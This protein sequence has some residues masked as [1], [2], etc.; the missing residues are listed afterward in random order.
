MLV[1]EKRGKLSVVGGELTALDDAPPIEQ[2]SGHSLSDIFENAP[3]S[4]TE[5]SD[6]TKN[7]AQ[8][9][10][11]KS[12]NGQTSIPVEWTATQLKNHPQADCI[13]VLRSVAHE[14][15]LKNLIERFDFIFSMMNDYG[16][17]LKVLPDNHYKFIWV[18]NAFKSITGYDIDVDNTTTILADLYHPDD[19]S[20]MMKHFATVREGQGG[21]QEYRIQTKSGHVR[22]MREYA[23]LRVEDGYSV[24]CGSVSDITSNV[25]AEQALN[26]YAMQQGVIAEVGM[27]AVN[28]QLDVDDFAGQVL[29]LIL[30]LMEAPYCT[31]IE[32]DEENETFKFHTVAGGAWQ[33]KIASTLDDKTSYLGYVLHQNDAV[34]VND[35]S[36]ENRF[37]K[38]Q[39]L[40]VNNI[41]SSVSVVVPMQTAPFGILNLHSLK[42]YAFTPENI[43]TLQMIAN[44]I[45]TYIQQKH[46]QKA[47]H[48]HHMIAQALSDIA[49][50]LNSATELDDILLIILNF[51]AQIVPVVDSSNIML[52]DRERKTATISIRHNVSSEVV[53]TPSGQEMALTDI[54]LYVQMMET[55]KPILLNDVTLESRWH[56]VPA[57]HWIQSWIGAPIF[58]GNEF[59][60][61]VNLDSARRN[62]FTQDHLE[63][64]EVFMNHAS[65]AI[66][67]ARQAEKLKLEVENQTRQL[68]SERAQLQAFFHATGEGIFYSIS[69]T[70]LF[71]NQKLC[72]MMGYSNEELLGRQSTMLRPLQL[73]PEEL[74]QR[75]RIENELRTTGVSHSE[76]RFQRKNGEIFI[77]AVTAS[78]VRV[79]DDRVVAVTIIRDI[80]EEIKVQEQRN[81]FISHAAHE[82]RNPITALNTR[83]YLMNKKEQVTTT[84]V[85]KVEQ[86]VKKMNALVSGLLDFSRYQSGRIP[87]TFESVI[88]QK[89]LGDV[90]DIQQPEADKENQT[91]VFEMPDEPITMVADELRLYQIVTNLVSNALHYTQPDG[92]IR[93]SLSYTDD[94]NSE[95][96]LKVTDNG[97]GIPQDKLESL[98]QPFFRVEQASGVQGAG[99]G[100]SITKQLVEAHGGEIRVESEIGVGSTFIVT[101][102]V[103]TL[104]D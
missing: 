25:M 23:Y 65:I 27:V 6:T 83:V 104:N 49:A 13:L 101:I 72:D 4:L 73:T 92:I 8:C 7:H 98:F 14:I 31:L 59:L 85:E 82:L 3:Q 43:T 2:L 91:L 64:L 95:I 81:S 5:L 68:E 11:L 18:S 80:S 42:P 33:R 55:G 16:Y 93:V 34:I 56:I 19:H 28:N 36:T 10:T 100:L 97:L 66:Q 90:Q 41:Q 53:T 22:H 74:E 67:N 45:G 29:N 39:T 103:A 96:M 32:I 63:Q 78:R 54:P 70:M 57:T 37:P 99:L 26:S 15:D 62:A 69:K 20:R 88:V 52:L 102:P 61:V 86:I 79:D 30:Q 44:I 75:K 76:I 38:P 21:V 47:E 71:V 12:P 17:L 60:G 1:Q 9:D 58:A 87:L 40:V 94:T 35:W 24:I 51:V 84:D 89:V 48:E 50:L 46:I 77:G